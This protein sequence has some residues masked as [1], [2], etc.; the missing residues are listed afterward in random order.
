MAPSVKRGRNRGLRAALVALAVIGL[1]ISAYLTWVHF[2]GIA[3]VCA[4]GSHGCETVQ[5]SR[6]ASLAGVPVPVLGLVGYALLFVSALVREEI[7]AY[8]GLLVALV[9]TLFSAYLTYLELFV[10]HAIC[11]WCVASALVM[12]LSLVAAFARLW[13]LSS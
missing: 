11:Q 1:G 9:G 2:E 5:S 10:I 4:G 12:L 13:R 6:Y 8:L 7:G 3:P